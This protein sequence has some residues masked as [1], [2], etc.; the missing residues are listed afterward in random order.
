MGIDAIK[1]QNILAYESDCYVGMT[2]EE[3]KE[4]GQSIF[5]DFKKIDDG[6]KTL[7]FD[8]IVEQR[9]KMAT[10]KRRWGNLCLGLGGYYCLNGILLENQPKELQEIGSEIASKALK[11]K[12]TPNSTKLMNL[13]N[14]LVFTGIGIAKYV[15]SR[16]IDK[17]TQEYANQY[18]QQV[19]D[20]SKAEA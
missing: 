8:E 18:Y 6:D 20:N 5:Q 17:E 12:I 10:K 13:L 3:A 11:T 4:S 9:D 16:K 15:K 1:N 2:A 14:V 7:S 19:A